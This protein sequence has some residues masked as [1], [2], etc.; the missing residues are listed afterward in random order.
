[1]QTQFFQVCFFVHLDS[2]FSTM[3]SMT[4]P[5]KARGLCRCVLGLGGR[6]QAAFCSIAYLRA[7]PQGRMCS[8][9]QVSGSFSQLICLSVFEVFLEGKLSCFSPESPRA[10]GSDFSCWPDAQPLCKEVQPSDTAVLLH[11]HAN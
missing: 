1:M 9:W 10:W 5:K 6:R 7:Q 3:K 4:V 2:Y 11:F 8:S